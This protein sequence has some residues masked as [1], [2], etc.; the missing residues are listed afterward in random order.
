MGE[1]AHWNEELRTAFRKVDGK[2]ELAEPMDI[3][4][5]KGLEPDAYCIATFADGSAI[6]MPG[7]TNQYVIAKFVKRES[8]NGVKGG[9]TCTVYWKGDRNDNL[10][11]LKQ[12]KDRRHLLALYEQKKIF[13]CVVVNLFGDDDTEFE[14]NEDGTPKKWPMTHRRF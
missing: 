13:L 6:A 5:L 1:Y 14:F 11:E 3:S 2:D 8:S 10:L 4:T 7:V 12:N 9:D